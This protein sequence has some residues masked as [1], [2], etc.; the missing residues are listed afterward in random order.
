[1]QY[2]FSTKRVRRYACPTQFTALVMDRSEAQASEVFIVVLKPGQ[3]PPVHQ[4]D[5]TEQ[6]FYILE[7]RGV[8]QIN[9][10]QEHAVQPGDVV[11][12]PPKTWHSIRATGDTTLRY[13]AIDAFLG[14]RP[15][16]EPTW[17]HRV[18]SIC[19]EEG[20]NYDDVRQTPADTDQ[21]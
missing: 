8:L 4:H 18:R 13:L 1:M 17:D 7:G 20:W 19:R 6:V 2:V 9:R 21:R 10:E 12:I 5:D 3:A 14:G 11:R 16:D 15:T